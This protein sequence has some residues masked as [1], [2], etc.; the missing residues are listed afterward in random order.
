[1]YELEKPELCCTECTYIPTFHNRYADLERHCLEHHPLQL[2][3]DRVKIPL[4]TKVI[5]ML[6]EFFSDEIKTE[7]KRN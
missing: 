1:M 2:K 6:K 7:I 5:N 3:Q 4:K